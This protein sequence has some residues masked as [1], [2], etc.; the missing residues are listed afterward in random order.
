MRGLSEILDTPLEMLPSAG[1]G[2]VPDFAGLWESWSS[3]GPAVFLES[4]G[5][6]G[7]ASQWLILAGLPQAEYFERDEKA[8]W[9]DASGIQP[10]SIDFWRFADQVGN[11]QRNFSTLPSCLAQAWFG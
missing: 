5:L 7:S 6:L 9:G 1:T 10:A 3:K 11:A 2:K 4:A 8:W